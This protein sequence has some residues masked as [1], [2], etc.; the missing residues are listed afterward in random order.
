MSFLRLLGALL[1]SV[2][3]QVVLAGIWPR[4]MAFFDLPLIVVL[5]YGIFR[6]PGSALMVGVAAGLL[7][8]TLQ[9]TLLGL[10]A[11][12]KALV[13]YLVGMMGLRLALSP[14]LPRVLVIAAATVLSRSIEM[15]TLAIMGRRFAPSPYPFLLEAM[16][17]T[18]ILGGLLI[19]AV[20]DD[21][22]MAHHR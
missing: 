14:A 22:A 16:I 2:V 9:G 10:N 17:G 13:G 15:G 6:G 12:S 19:G 21:D 5:Y 4:V 18:C 11:L 7:Q 8:D 1:V 20:R 3:L